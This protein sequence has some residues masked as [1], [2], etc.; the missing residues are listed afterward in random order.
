MADPT[1][2]SCLQGTAVVDAN[3]NCLCI[4]STVVPAVPPPIQPLPYRRPMFRGGE[5]QTVNTYNYYL[6]ST[7][8]PPILDGKPQPPPQTPAKAAPTT[9][10]GLSPLVALGV[11]AVALFALSS[12][13]GKKSKLT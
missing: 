5:P 1:N 9:I 10:F 3:G 11:A 2:C 7:P 6:P 4:D 12:M 8:P 13:D